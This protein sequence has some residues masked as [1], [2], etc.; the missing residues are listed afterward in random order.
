MTPSLH[1]AFD[2]VRAGVRALGPLPLDVAAALQL[3][4]TQRLPALGK[5]LRRVRAWTAFGPPGGDWSKVSG[6]IA[7]N[8]V[9]APDGRG[10]VHRRADRR[11]V[12]KRFHPGDDNHFLAIDRLNFTLGNGRSRARATGPPRDD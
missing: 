8:F 2:S 11:D 12:K 4:A 3:P 7:I 10:L 5:A 9:R 6:Q 1:G